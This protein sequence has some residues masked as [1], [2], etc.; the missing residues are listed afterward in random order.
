MQSLT[1]DEKLAL[2]SKK[3]REAYEKYVADANP[4]LASSTSASLFTLYSQGFST[5]EILKVNPSLGLGIIVKA[6]IDDDWDTKKQEC[7]EN[8]LYVARETV[9]K[10]Q[11]ETIR[12]ICTAIAVYQKSMGDRFT[13]Y[14]QTGDPKLLVDSKGDE[15]ISYKK[16]KDLVEMLQALTGA[17]NKVS[18]EVVHTHQVQRGSITIEPLSAE[19]ILKQLDEGEKK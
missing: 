1:K 18:G 8:L 14:L 3:E 11:L 16:F 12:F 19:A 6:R 10:T 15:V 17:D 2:L 7:V 4:R 13:K 5:E 9:Q